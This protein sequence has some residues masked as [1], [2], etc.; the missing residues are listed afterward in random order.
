MRTTLQVLF[1]LILWVTVSVAAIYSPF[2][3]PWEREDSPHAYTLT[4]RSG[5]IS[6]LLLVASQWLAAKIFRRI[7]KAS[8]MIGVNIAISLIDL[9][10]WPFLAQ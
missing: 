7:P 8:L 5:I 4:W 9:G 2:P 6:F 10:A 3:L 1:G